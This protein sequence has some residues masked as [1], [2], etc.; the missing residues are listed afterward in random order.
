MCGCVGV[1]FYEGV[2]GMTTLR[3]RATKDFASVVLGYG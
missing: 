2:V 3:E 1:Q